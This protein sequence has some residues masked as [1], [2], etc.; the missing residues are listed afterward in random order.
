MGCITC[1][2]GNAFRRG[3]CRPFEVSDWRSPIP[4]LTHGKS[5][6]A[7]TERTARSS[8]LRAASPAAL[9]AQ[10][11][12]ADPSQSFPV[13]T[14]HRPRSR[15]F[16]KSRQAA[17]PQ[18]KAGVALREE[19]HLHTEPAEQTPAPR[20]SGEVC[21]LCGQRTRGRAGLQAGRGEALRPAPK[22]DGGDKDRRA[23]SSWRT[24][25]QVCHLLRP[26]TREKGE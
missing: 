10:N 8:S 17:H 26:P 22:S 9:L 25:A 5:A 1:N 15:L 7:Q 6:Q 21:A 3:F 24:A 13:F 19:R 20:R 23:R 12:F 18:V 2:A 11:R 14:L 4:L 16:Q